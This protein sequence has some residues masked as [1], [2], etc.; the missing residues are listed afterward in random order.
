MLMSSTLATARAKRELCFSKVV[1]SCTQKQ[2]QYANMLRWSA[3]DTEHQCHGN[4]FFSA[5]RKFVIEKQLL[6]A[7]PKARDTTY[8]K[9]LSVRFCARLLHSIPSD[10]HAK[11]VKKR[12]SGCSIL[13]KDKKLTNLLLLFPFRQFPPNP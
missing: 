4:W 12:R 7:F 2:A 13:L 1:S 8:V 9:R 11:P 6:R 5:V 10:F 3:A